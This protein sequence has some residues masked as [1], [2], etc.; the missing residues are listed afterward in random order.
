MEKKELNIAI[1]GSTRGTDMEGI[2]QGIKEGKL[3][4]EISLVISDRKD[5][6]IL[7][8]AKKYGIPTLF[9]N[10]KEYNSREEF[11]QKIKEKLEEVK[12]QLILLIGY[13]RFLSPQ[14]VQSFRN[15]IMN[16]HPSLLPAFAGGMD[17]NVHEEVLKQGVKVTGCTLHFVDEGADTGPIILQKA[18]YVEEHDTADSLKVKVQAAEQEVLREGI[19][20][21]QE[22]KLKV[23][24][25]RVRILK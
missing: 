11:D 23:T 22:N 8:R 13:M 1:L 25:Q 16:I 7:E 5:A 18:V 3:K 10:P 21:F 2:I 14:L 4:A 6:Y 19:K 24:E 17:L 15:K 9:L 12:V 20:L